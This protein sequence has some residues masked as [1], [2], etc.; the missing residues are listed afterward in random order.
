[1]DERLDRW[2]SLGTGILALVA[3]CWA[4][5]VG[6]NAT[7][8]G[9]M[10]TVFGLFSVDGAWVVPL[11]GVVL[12]VLSAA[13]ALR[14]P[15]WSWG[16][17]AFGVVA[18]GAVFGVASSVSSMADEINDWIAAEGTSSIDSPLTRAI[19]G[20]SSPLTSVK[21]VVFSQV[22][23]GAGI[24]AGLCALN[25]ARCLWARRRASAALAADP[26]EVTA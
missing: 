22:M 17:L 7:R 25:A 16:S 14:D 5:V 24:L 19:G 12:A 18:A 1:M 3:L 6:I 10:E 21:T 26:A 4:G 15:R 23:T 20:G 2:V 13:V 11:A 9:D 8:D